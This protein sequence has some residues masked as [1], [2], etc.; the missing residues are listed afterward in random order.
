MSV[1]ILLLIARYKQHFTLNISVA[2]AWM[3]HGGEW[4]LN[5]PL[6]KASYKMTACQCKTVE[7]NCSERRL[8]LLL[9]LQPSLLTIV[10]TT[11]NRAA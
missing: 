10:L 6:M 2:S 11:V 9:S 8:T 1:E 7:G 5:H 4:K 3:R